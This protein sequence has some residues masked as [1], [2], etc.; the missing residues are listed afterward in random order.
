[1]GP[2]I[3]E[4]TFSLYHPL[5]PVVILGNRRYYRDQDIRVISNIQDLKEGICFYHLDK[6]D[7]QTDESFA[8]VRKAVDLALDGTVHAL[9]TAP[10]SKTK[11]MEKGIRFAGHTGYLARRANVKKYGMF[12]WSEDLRVSL[13]TVHISLKEIFSYIRKQ[14]IRD[15]LRFTNRELRRLFGKEFVFF[16]SGLNPHAGEQG[17]LG[18]EEKRIINPILK[19]L[20]EEMKIAGLYPPDTVFS[21]ARGVKDSVVVCWYHDQGLIPF[22]LFR[23]RPGVNMTLGLPFIR[24]SPDHGTA[25]DIAGQ[26]VADPASMIEA[27]KLADN[28]LAR[29]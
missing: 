26:G 2:E 5:H 7:D 21:M 3:I 17:H 19:E 16:I 22:K 29:K 6:P 13:F 4:K 1:M 20:K 23:E 28:L 27:V 25:I 11:W 24:T 9:V 18:S 15:F 14:K 8:C 12:F 10:I